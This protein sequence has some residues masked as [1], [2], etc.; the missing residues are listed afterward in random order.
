LGNP[1]LLYIRRSLPLSF[2]GCTKGLDLPNELKK[3]KRAQKQ[4]AQKQ[5][6]QFSYPIINELKNKQRAQFKKQTQIHVL[7]DK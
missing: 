5:R 1:A 3:N 7:P 2:S 6:A 4:R